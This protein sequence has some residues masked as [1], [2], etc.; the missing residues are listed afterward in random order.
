MRTVAPYA[1]RRPGGEARPAKVLGGRG[2]QIGGRSI[3]SMEGH[4]ML[5][6]PCFLHYL[7]ADRHVAWRRHA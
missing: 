6:C 5:A 1:D 7:A 4:A 3:Y 2:W